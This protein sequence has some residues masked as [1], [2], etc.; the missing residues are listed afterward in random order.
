[1]EADRA[2]ADRI[3]ALEQSLIDERAVREQAQRRANELEQRVATWRTRAEERASRIERLERER[4]ERAN[5]AGWLRSQVATL[6]GSAAEEAD[7]AQAAGGLE[8]AH[9]TALR[10]SLPGTSIAHNIEG[11]LA[12]ILGQA[13]AVDLDERPWDA[14]DLV[15]VDP[16]RLGDLDRLDSWLDLAPRPPTVVVSDEPHRWRGAETV[17]G[18]GPPGEGRNLSLPEPIVEA[19]DRSIT[20]ILAGTSGTIVDESGEVTG[21]LSELDDSTSGAIASAAASGIPV[22]PSRDLVRS[23]G[24]STRSRRWAWEHR[25]PAVLL[26]ELLDRVGVAHKPLL[27]H[28]AGLLISNRPDRVVTAVEGFMAQTYSECELVVGCHGISTDP[29][30]SLVDEQ[31]WGDAVSILDLPTTMPLG[32]CTNEAAAATTAS[33]LA[34]IDDDDHYGPGYLRDAVLAMRYSG[35]PVIGKAA[36]FTYVESADRTVLR[37]A[38]TEETMVTGILTG[39]TLVFERAIWDAVRFPDRPRMIDIHFLNGVRAAG[40]TVYANSRWEFVYRRGPGAHT[41]DISD[42]R[43]LEAS[44]PAWDGW[45]PERSHV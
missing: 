22:A 8:T 4:R 16:A 2:D 12:T 11:P 27:P 17:I 40:G 14:V 37:R 43:T 7:P 44:E 23:P 5:P 29:L 31:G 39:A 24:Q 26:T 20:E 45:R 34:K 9:P 35:A 32:S 36:Q 3:E 25:D 30:R 33:V 13:D 10:R 38:Q 42:E 1:M 19:S 6:R 21:I 18:A 15:V 41:W 28:T